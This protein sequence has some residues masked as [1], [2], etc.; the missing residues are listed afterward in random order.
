MNRRIVYQEHT[1]ILVTSN[2]HILSTERFLKLDLGE[3]LE[4]HCDSGIIRPR[5][6]ISDPQSMETV[7]NPIID[8]GSMETNASVLKIRK[9][10]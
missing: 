9:L 1:K 4:E 3:W 10:S 8:F 7:A 5:A 2:S 6:P